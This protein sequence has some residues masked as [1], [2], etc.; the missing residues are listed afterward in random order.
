MHRGSLTYFRKWLN[1]VFNKVDFHRIKEVGPDRAA[2]EWLLRCGASVKWKSNSEWISDYNTL[3][4]KYEGNKMYI[5]EID[6]T[7]SC[8]MHYGFEYLNGLMYVKSFTLCKCI[9]F[10]DRSI[11]RLSVLKD[12]LNNLKI[13]SCGNVTDEGILK[14]AELKKLKYL[15]LQDLPEVVNKENCIDFLRENLPFCKTSFP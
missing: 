10:D 8:I 13:I 9:Y 11:A 3:T 15:H 7:N 12:S 2:A 14:I 5:E 6:A 1:T 4:E